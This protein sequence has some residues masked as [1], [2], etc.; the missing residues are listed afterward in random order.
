MA[1]IPIFDGTNYKIWS[2]KMKTML[3]SMDLWDTVQNGY[4]DESNKEKQ[5]KDA[6]ALY[7]IQQGVSDQIFPRIK[8]ATKAKQAWGILSKEPTRPHYG[9]VVY[10]TPIDLRQTGENHLIVAT[11]VA[12]VAFTAGFTM[13]GGYNGNDGP[14]QGMA[15][16][17]REAAFK[18]FMVIDTIATSLSISAVLTHFYAAGSNNGDEVEKLVHRAAYLTIYAAMAM[19]LAFVTGTYA[20]LAHS[21]GLAISVCVIGCLPLLYFLNT[22]IMVLRGRY[23]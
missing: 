22:R 23:W 11:L 3:L 12:T 8:D 1:T 2:V 9:N 10:V 14:N 19:V 4:D 18:A 20:V 16:L 6:A 7:H 13:P 5:Q 21:S 15:I 17:T